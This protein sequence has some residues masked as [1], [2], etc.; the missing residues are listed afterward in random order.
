MQ[1]VEIGERIKVRADFTPAGRIIPLMFRRGRHDPLRI[2]RINATWEE[3]GHGSRTVYFSVSVE[4][5]DD[6][7]HLRYR[8]EDRTWWLDSLAMDG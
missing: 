1:V 4:N 8:E 7:F 6:V 5:S 2:R 3:R